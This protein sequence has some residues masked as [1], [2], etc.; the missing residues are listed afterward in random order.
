[1]TDPRRIELLAD[2][3]RPGGMMLIMDSVL[4]SY[5]DLSDPHYLDFE[6]VQFFACLLAEITEPDPDRP[7]AVT[8]IGGGGLTLPRYL[9][10]TCPGSSHI[11]L[12][13]DVV[14]T[15]LVRRELPLPRR[16]RIRVRPQDGR[17]G[18]ARLADSSADVI[19]LDAFADG[20]VPAELTTVEFF[21]DCSRVLRADGVFLANLVDEPDLRYIGRSTAGLSDV[22][23]EVVLVSSV[24]VLKGRRFGNVV[25]A[26]SSAPLDVDSLS[27]RL[28]RQPF[29]AR[30]VAG[31]DLGRRFAGLRAWTDADSSVSPEPARDGWRVR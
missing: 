26:G 18:I 29:P 17:T 12:E 7:L 25:L 2:D 16:H 28:A 3:D 22:F 30:A 6:Y 11:V 9:V 5:V 21:T 8:H 10:A 4:Q 23:G 31:A 14:L 27:R 19:V 15:E 20:R 24:D 1:M 13:P